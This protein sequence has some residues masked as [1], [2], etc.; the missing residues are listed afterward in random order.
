MAF[1]G[2]PDS[3]P[4]EDTCYL[5]SSYNLDRA[6]V[7]WERTALV[8]WVLSPPSGTDRS[9]VMDMFMHKFRL[10]AS[11]IMV[12]KHFSE[13]YLVKL[14]S[15]ELRDKLMR[16]DRASFKLDG[17]EVHFRPW[18]AVSHA[19]NANLYYRL[20]LHLEG[21]P[22]FAWRPEVVDQIL[23]HKCAVQRLDD[24]FT[25][26]E[27]TSS[28]GLWGW[29]PDPH[30]IPKVL[31]CTFANK[32]PGGL[33]S[34]VSVSEDRPDQWKRGVTFR[35]LIHFDLLEYYSDAPVLDGGAPASDYR[36]STRSLPHWRLGTMD[37]M[38]V[39]SGSILP[40]SIPPLAGGSGARCHGHEP[41]GAV[42]GVGAGGSRSGARRSSHA[43]R[44]DDQQHLS[45]PRGERSRSRSRHGRRCD[46]RRP[47]HHQRSDEEDDDDRY[48]GRGDG[49]ACRA[50]SRAPSASSRTHAGGH[51]HDRGH[52]GGSR[53]R[54]RGHGQDQGGRR[55]DLSS[56]QLA[57]VLVCAP[58]ST[59]CM[60]VPELVL[61]DVEVTAQ[62][63]ALFHEGAA[64]MRS[65]LPA[66]LG[67]APPP[68]P[69]HRDALGFS[70]TC[71]DWVTSIRAAPAA[72]TRGA[73]R[74]AS[75]PPVSFSLPPGW[76][77]HAGDPWEADEISPAVPPPVLP[78]IAGVEDRV[79]PDDWEDAEGGE[80]WFAGED[81][82]HVKQVDEEVE[83][84]HAI[85]LSAE[86]EASSLGGLLPFLSASVS[87][88]VG[89][90][91]ACEKSLEDNLFV[92]SEPP[93]LP[94]PLSRAPTPRAA[95]VSPAQLERRS[96]R[97][98]A[99]PAM[100]AL[101]RA[102]YVLA[103][104]MGIQAHEMPLELARKQYVANYKSS[105]PDFA[106]KA[107]L[108]FS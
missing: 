31:W 60:A 93:I 38:P 47:S 65:V 39:G 62:L 52:A 98:A 82:H 81:S 46:D 75:L 43:G 19:Y 24:N 102:V 67:L 48:D 25:T 41:H 1:I 3:R 36:P 51:R 61:S 90:G 103:K 13:E 104:K 73:S 87:A 84:G 9:D 30:H 11:Q 86:D 83:P 89:V 7:E 44:R 101:D 26:M 76:S 108:C 49:L 85:V 14:S 91:S 57:S 70:N 56:L 42:S 68:V 54:S 22:P 88:G 80:A 10:R 27:D 29:T 69:P 94:L 79:V 55:H 40:A 72:L 28:F 92:C 95:A 34:L 105:L 78:R 58:S 15:A 12:S 107:S 50:P 20:H 53:H 100:P 66:M 64:A 33:S 37:G 63:Q 16:M 17:L 71:R 74:L 4:E 35:V 106:I 99:K 2:A 96:S 77:G 8:A 5:A 45:R 97:L 59:L 21:V 32:A 6:R 23:G 18:R